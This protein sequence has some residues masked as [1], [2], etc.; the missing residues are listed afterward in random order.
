MEYCFI[1]SRE[2]FF[3]LN[4]VFLDENISISPLYLSINFL[5][6]ATTPSKSFCRASTLAHAI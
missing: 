3:I 1:L 5:I 4:I 2:N 6:F